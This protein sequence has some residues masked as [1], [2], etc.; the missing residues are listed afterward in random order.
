MNQVQIQSVR[1]THDAMI[2][3]IIA[4]PSVKG[5]ELAVLFG[6]T[7]G[8]VSTVINSDAFQERLSQRKG[9]LVDPGILLSV[10]EKFRNLAHKSLN[11]LLAKL[12][13]PPSM[14]PDAVA[15]EGTKIA[16]RALNVGGFGN[17]ITAPPAAPS[18]RLEKLAERLNSFLG[19]R[20]PL[21]ST[22]TIQDVE[23]HMVTSAA[24]SDPSSLNGAA[25]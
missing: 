10:N 25:Q 2:D 1:Y 12:D 15:L 16:A 21:S 5:K 7:E 14:V 23:A 8:W 22:V 13:M 24:G 19:P 3:M 17:A 20:A 6:F 18:D 11:V 4:N 9:E